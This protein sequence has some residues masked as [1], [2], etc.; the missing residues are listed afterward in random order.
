MRPVRIRVQRIRAKTQSRES[1][2]LSTAFYFSL[3]GKY[4]ALIILAIGLV[5]ILGA[6]SVM[7]KD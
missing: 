4:V 5:L 7:L 3:H 1:Q 6:I 2:M